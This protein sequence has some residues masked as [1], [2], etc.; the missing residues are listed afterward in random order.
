VVRRRGSRLL[1]AIGPAPAAVLQVESPA[2]VRGFLGFSS[3][4]DQV[5]RSA[6][7]LLMMNPRLIAEPQNARLYRKSAKFSVN[8]LT[9]TDA[10][11]R[12]MDLHVLTCVF[13]CQLTRL[14]LPLC[15]E[16]H[17]WMLF[18][19]QNKSLDRQRLGS[20]MNEW[21]TLWFSHR[22]NENRFVGS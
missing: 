1:T 19:S 21:T 3:V 11:S 9:Q 22:R 17:V 15:W 14:Y 10:L 4:G 5:I 20:M 6:I 7:R 8:R 18:N 13:L 2:E 16:C 12:S